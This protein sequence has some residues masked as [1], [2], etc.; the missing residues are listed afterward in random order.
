MKKRL[1]KPQRELLASLPARVSPNR[2]EV[3]AL[4]AHGLA[5]IR[6]RREDRPTVMLKRTEKGELVCQ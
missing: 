4:I 3:K 6:G 2:P 1:T 5:V